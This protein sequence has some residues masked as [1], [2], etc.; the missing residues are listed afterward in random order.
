MLNHVKTFRWNVCSQWF[1]GAQSPLHLMLILAYS[2]FLSEAFLMF[3]LAVLPPLSVG[4]DL[5]V[6]PLASASLINLLVPSL[7]YSVF[8]L[9]LRG[10]K[11]AVLPPL[12]KATL[13][14]TLD[15]LDIRVQEC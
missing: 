12:A 9:L 5:H 2:I 10:S 15:Q 4:A 13:R 3:L 7:F 8:R 11:G 1:V 14:V 6:C